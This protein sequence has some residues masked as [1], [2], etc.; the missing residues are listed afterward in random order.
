[1]AD[2][3]RLLK[4]ITAV[5]TT[6]A[7][8]ITTYN[9]SF[10]FFEH[11]VLRR[12]QS[13][14]CGHVVL[15]LDEDRFREAV[16]SDDRRP[17]LAGV[18]YTILPMRYPGAFHPKLLM[19]VGENHGRLWLGSHNLTLAGFNHNVEL[20]TYA[21]G[22]RDESGR[23]LLKQA[24]RALRRW[25][26]ESA[27]P[28]ESLDLVEHLAPWLSE[29]YEIEGSDTV[30]ASHRGMPLWP[31]IRERLP[32]GLQRVVLT[33]PFFDQALDFLHTLC[34]AAPDAEVVVGLRPH[35]AAF[36]AHR[37]KDLPGRLRFVDATALMP[38]KRRSSYLH[39]K[40]ILFEGATSTL[41]VAGSA[42]PSAPAFL[43]H[44]RGNAEA[45]IA[46]VLPRGADP[47]GLLAL[48]GAPELDDDAW[49]H[50]EDPRDE[51]PTAAGPKVWTVIL[52]G[53]DVAV[54]KDLPNHDRVVFIGEAG[55]DLGSTAPGASIA[56][57]DSQLWP[58]VRWIRLERAGEV[59]GM[60]LVHHRRRLARLAR[61]REDLKLTDAL[62][63][64]ETRV[65]DLAAVL[66]LLDPILE[67]PAKHRARR[68]R[69]PP[70]RGSAGIGSG[71]ADAETTL[72]SDPGDLYGT[73]GDLAE[74][75]LY[76]HHRLGAQVDAVERS[77]EEVV[78]TDD[79]AYVVEQRWV[80][81]LEVREQVRHRFR[82][83]RKKLGTILQKPQ[84]EPR[85]MAHDRIAKLS[86]ILGLAN[87][88]VR[89][90]TPEPWQ[91]VDHLRLASFE[92]LGQLLYDGVGAATFNH[93]LAKASTTL[94]SHAEEVRSVPP[95]LAWLCRELDIWPPKPAPRHGRP[96]DGDD[97]V[98]RAVWVAVFPSLDKDQWRRLVTL[99][100]ASDASEAG[101]RW[102][103][104]ARK[105]TLHMRRVLAEPD[106][107]IERHR[108][109]RPGDIVMMG[110]GRGAILRVVR[111]EIGGP[112]RQRRVVWPLPDD[113]Y[114][115]RAF[116]HTTLLKPEVWR[117]TSAEGRR[118]R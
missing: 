94:G 32:A 95:L 87:A 38:E 118:G 56:P 24:W 60:L 42:N 3:A 27:S 81:S 5:K 35:E 68:V 79:E 96:P 14:G 33:G 69:E 2:H 101:E 50:V 4:A 28:A 13:V 7:A 103:R 91:R 77:E 73:E 67:Q 115:S 78:G 51:E 25:G 39:A 53:H 62:R 76:V 11:V 99:V 49:D 100:R 22:R 70:K 80:P 89:R 18:E 88:T 61:S 107:H 83:V 37:R 45:V 52:D 8:V 72:P 66:S 102:L 97:L 75:M 64:L 86:A 117:T 23:R 108:R 109:A 10:P 26:E 93:D 34:A 31:Q 57:T 106:A 114:G 36:P 41:L 110:S 43:R 21:S 47:L 9:A 84:Y 113:S 90:A 59:V 116:D 46:R 54:P 98:D 65:P 71:G 19:Q 29:P 63:S 1:M 92:D 74:V 6:R 16:A 20:T 111:E 12:L 58:R 44:P 30:V 85:S 15:F 112:K 104:A 17:R 48:V 105:W 40:A 82:R 55:T